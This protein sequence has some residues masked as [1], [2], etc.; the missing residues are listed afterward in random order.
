MTGDNTQTTEIDNSN[1]NSEL[2]SDS[3]ESVIRTDGINPITGLKDLIPSLCSISVCAGVILI[4]FS[5]KHK[6]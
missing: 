4:L 1:L 3:E 6:Q 5:R 2:T